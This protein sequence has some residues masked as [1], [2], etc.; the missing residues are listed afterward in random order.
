MTHLTY[1]PIS[2][3]KMQIIE[4]VN[5][6]FESVEFKANADNQSLQFDFS[7][8]ANVDFIDCIFSAQNTRFFISNQAE[9]SFEGC[10]FLNILGFEDSMMSISESAV[11]IQQTAFYG[12]SH[13]ETILSVKTESNVTLKDIQFTNNTNN[14]LIIHSLDSF[15]KI[16]KSPIDDS[17]SCGSHH[18]I[19]HFDGDLYI[20]N[21]SASNQRVQFGHNQNTKDPFITLFALNIAPHLVL[22]SIDF[23]NF[24]KENGSIQFEPCTSF[25]SALFHDPYFHKIS[26]HLEPTKV[27]KKALEIYKDELICSD[28]FLCFIQCEQSLASCFESEFISNESEIA[29]FGCLSERACQ[30]SKISIDSAENAAILCQQTSSCEA[31]DILVMNTT[32]FSLECVEERACMDLSIKMNETM[33]ANITCF[34]ENSCKNIQ[35]GSDSNDN[36]KL[37]MFHWSES[38]KIEI[39]SEFNSDS[40]ECDPL[41]AYLRV[42]GLTFDGSL[43]LFEQQSKDLFNEHMP[44]DDILYSFDNEDSVE[45]EVRYYF[46]ETPLNEALTDFEQIFECFAAIY[47]MDIADYRCFGTAA[48]TTEPT[49]NPS[50]EPSFVP[51][52]IPTTAPS[53]D[54][55][56]EPTIN[57]K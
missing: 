15:V 21:I 25:D 45:C 4:S 39:P 7:N 48:P 46:N 35:I 55:T 49:N 57:P 9:I 23:V 27:F 51:T 2:N 52:N 50:I 20:D 19:S 24:G 22:D 26:N 54:P 56:L 37:T 47:I 38:I 30:Q 18:C 31:M 14:S 6:K 40:L 36:I 43:Q 42:N 11:S 32:D 1:Y 33:N 53:I 29:L 13:F 5:A 3:H 28:P 10:T 17:N 8:N 12:I 41:R 44:C 34:E 16:T